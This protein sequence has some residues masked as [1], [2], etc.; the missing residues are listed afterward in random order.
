MPR[1]ARLGVEFDAVL[2]L[3]GAATKEVQRFCLRRAG[4]IHRIGRLVEW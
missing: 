4:G 2:R 3:A 1:L